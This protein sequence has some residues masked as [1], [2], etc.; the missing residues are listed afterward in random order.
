[1]KP[2]RARTGCRSQGARHRCTDWLGVRLTFAW[3]TLEDALVLQPWA[4]ADR[5]AAT[6]HREPAGAWS[7]FRSAGR[8]SS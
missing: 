8:A 6:D 1:M 5:S 7:R 2:Y 3:L 4:A